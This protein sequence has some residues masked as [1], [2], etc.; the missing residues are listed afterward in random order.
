MSERGGAGSLTH[1]IDRGV[2]YRIDAD[3]RLLVV[4]Y[5]GKVTLDDIRAAQALVR[6]DPQFDASFSM[7]LDGSHGDFSGLSPDDLQRIGIGT[8]GRP[9]TKRAFV[10]NTQVNYGL[11]RMFHSLAAARGDD[12]PVAL[13]ER[14]EDA[15][16]WL[17]SAA[18]GPTKSAPPK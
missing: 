14:L 6:A 12:F 8:P 2:S 9:G 7:L 18:T 3:R 17:N 13:F 16:R 15:V 10:V 1:G 4:T 11:V 5:I